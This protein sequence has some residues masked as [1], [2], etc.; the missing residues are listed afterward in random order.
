M[1]SYKQ[2]MGLRL[3]PMQKC[4]CS[5]IFKSTERMWKVTLAVD[6][7]NTIYL[8]WKFD[9]CN[10][11]FA[12]SRLPGDTQN[13]GNW[14]ECGWGVDNIHIWNMSGS[15]MKCFCS[16]ISK[17]EWDCSTQSLPILTWLGHVKLL[18]PWAQIIWRTW[19]DTNIEIEMNMTVEFST[20][21][22]TSES[23]WARDF[24][25]MTRPALGPTQ[26][27]VQWIPGLS[28]AWRW[29]LTPF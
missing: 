12:H 29:P 25:H 27:P 18:F 26:P 20:V 5:S 4:D 6:N 8:Q 19:F 24:P 9:G 10:V 13:D 22:K 1:Q 16:H 2:F 28:G 15:W 7:W 14:S 23:R 3:C 21:T 11:Q 17:F